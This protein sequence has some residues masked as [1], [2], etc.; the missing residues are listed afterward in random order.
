MVFQR[1]GLNPLQ[2][3]RGVARVAGRAV[4][5]LAVLALRLGDCAVPFTRCELG[6]QVAC[7]V[8]PDADAL[9]FPNS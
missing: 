3:V 2:L 6:S 9:S 5:V 4:A 8:R 7:V 1:S